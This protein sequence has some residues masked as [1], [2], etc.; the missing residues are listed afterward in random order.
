MSVP[1]LP[2]PT[3]GIT[4]VFEII[5]LLLA[6]EFT[7]GG[8]FWLPRAWSYKPLPSGVLHRVLPRLMKGIRW[9]ET[10]M[11]PWGERMMRKRFSVIACGLT[12]SVCIA[13][14]FLA[15]PFSGLDTLPALG[16]VLLCFALLV[17]DVR[18]VLLGCVV[19]SVG[20]GLEVVFGAVLWNVLRTFV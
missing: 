16:A 18:L 14:A 7:A 12:L 17:R 11:Q 8:N 1:A 20:I 15:P 6:I 19:G 13:A 3:G 2:L 10:R 5:A 9:Y 4:H